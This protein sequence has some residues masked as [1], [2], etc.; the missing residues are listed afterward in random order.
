MR[1]HTRDTL[2]D[3]GL[4]TPAAFTVAAFSLPALLSVPFFLAG[5]ALFAG[6]PWG[7]HGAV[8]GAIAVPVLTLVG[9]SLAVRRL[10][11][12]GRWACALAI[13]SAVQLALASSGPGGLALHPS[14][15]AL[16]LTASIVFL[17][18]AER[19]R[20]ARTDGG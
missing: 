1:R 8:G 20:S 14:N 19:R 12:F 9:Y 18:R 3:P 5:Q 6:L 17:F 15:A 13:L 2:T 7:L 11:G 4:G 16:R 10:R